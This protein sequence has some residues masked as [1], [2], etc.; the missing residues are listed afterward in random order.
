[1]AVLMPFVTSISLPSLFLIGSIAAVGLYEV[2]ARREAKLSRAFGGFLA[3]AGVGVTLM[4]ALGQYHASLEDGDY[5]IQFW[6]GAFPPSWHDPMALAGWLFRAHTGPLFAYPQ[7]ANRLTW[8]TIL[9]FGCFV[10]GIVLWGRRSPRV[11]LLLVMPFVLALW[12]AALRRYPYG[13]SVR[14]AQFLVPSTLLLASAGLAWVAARLKPSSVARWAIPGL[15]VILVASAAWRLAHDLGNAE[16]T[17]WDR[18]SREFARWFWNELAADA[19]LVCVRTDLGI[20]FRPGR[21]AYDGADQYLC[22]QRIYSRRHQRK[23]PPRWDAISSTW[24]L[25]CVLLNRMPAE[26]PAFRG[27]IEA[28]RDR[29]TL[30]EVRTYPATRG[31]PVEPAQT[32]VVCEFIPT[33]RA[34]AAVR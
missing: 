8:L 19:E 22:F 12:A 27:W 2:L 20:P 7:G 25:R 31:S 16:R 21:W 6:K 30:R 24:P 32:Y 14:V 9:I 26:V 34:L 5:L 23:Q 29:Y 17:P 28:Q 11:V 15:A 1:L 13:L 10:L 3:A 18:T 33:P 4:S